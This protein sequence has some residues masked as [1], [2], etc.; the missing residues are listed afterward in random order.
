MTEKLYQKKKRIDSRFSSQTSE[1]YFS[2]SFYKKNRIGRRKY[3]ILRQQENNK[4]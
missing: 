2:C 4:N 3:R 1:G